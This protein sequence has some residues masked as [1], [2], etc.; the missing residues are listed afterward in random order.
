MTT[1]WCFLAVVMAVLM[2]EPAQA[3]IEVEGFYWHMMPRGDGS[4]GYGGTP[5]T[6]VDVEDDL[7]F[8][9]PRAVFGAKAFFGDVHQFGLGFVTTDLQSDNTITRDIQFRRF[10]YPANTRISSELDATLVLGFY[11]LNLGSSFAR[12]GLLLGAQYMSFGAEVSA[13]GLGSSSD[14]LQAVMPVGGLYFLGHPV[15]FLGARGSVMGSAWDVGDSKVSY[16]DIELALE[17][18]PFGG[19]FA[20][21]GYRYTSIYGEDEDA[22]IEL[23]LSLSGPI[24]YVGFEW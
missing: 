5:G 11:R 12:G 1:R 19:L 4:V 17:I 6:E 23:D 2:A 20:A 18:T 3:V 7:G 16:M 8:E 21:A 22:L 13:R 10:L 24:A 15:P 9:A 14:D